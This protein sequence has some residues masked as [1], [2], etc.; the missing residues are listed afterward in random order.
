MRGLKLERP[1]VFFD[2]ETTGVDVE[3]DRIVQIAIVR[4]EPLEERPASNDFDKLHDWSDVYGGI[5]TEYMCLVNPGVPIPE[6][7]SAVHGI[8]DEAVSDMPSFSD[9]SKEVEEWFEGADVCGHNVIKFDIPLLGNEMDRAG[10]A[11]EVTGGVV[12]TLRIFQGRF[13]HTLECAHRLYAGTWFAGAHDAGNDVD[14]LVAIL[15]GMMEE[16]PD[17]PNE[18]GLLSRTPPSPDWI[19]D[20]G[21]FI[22]ISGV[23]TLNFSK[24]KGRT[25]TE[26]VQHDHGFLQWMLGQ[27]F[28]AT[29][30]RVARRALKGEFPVREVTA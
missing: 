28:D 2:L 12:D 22:W 30:L 4:I 13:R 8:T 11:F 17:M 15:L 9:I 20:E 10:I 25:L 6:G 5:K 21:K 3:S 19:D 7:A 1:L 27:D 24:N 16:H 14:A 26:M 23:A 18:P 29:T